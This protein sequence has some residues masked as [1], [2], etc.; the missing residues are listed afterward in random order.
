VSGVAVAVLRENRLLVVHRSPRDGAYW[1]LVTGAVEPGETAEEAARRELAEEV[2]L[3][4]ARLEAA[5]GYAY[6]GIQVA[7]FAVAVPPTWEP[8]LN[9]EHDDH[10]W[11]DLAEAEDLLRWP[12]PRAL[13]ARLLR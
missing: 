2:G 12:E 11:C 1:H 8:E 7:A 5:G 6:D 9:E 3:A 13:A 4:G 10:R